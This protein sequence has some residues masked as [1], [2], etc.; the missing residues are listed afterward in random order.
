[1]N[2]EVIPAKTIKLQGKLKNLEERARNQTAVL[3]TYKTQFKEI[4]QKNKKEGEGEGH[5][6][7]LNE[8][9]A[10]KH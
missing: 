4:F 6:E 1:M 10:K 2:S 8:E 7:E 9:E 3:E 5:N